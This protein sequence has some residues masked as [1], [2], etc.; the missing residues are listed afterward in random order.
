MT[1]E[2]LAYEMN[3]TMKNLKEAYV[4][5]HPESP[6]LLTYIQY[7]RGDEMVAVMAHGAD[8]ETMMEMGEKGRFCFSADRVVM[9]YE[10]YVTLKGINPY[11]GDPW[12]PGDIQHAAENEGGLDRG[13]T[14][15]TVM[16]IGFEEGH[17]VSILSPYRIEGE[18]VIW[19][20]KLPEEIVSVAMV[21][22]AI[23]EFFS[24]VMKDI[25][26]ADVAMRGKRDP[27]VNAEDADELEAA[28]KILREGMTEEEQYYHVDMVGLKYLMNLPDRPPM[29]MFGLA[30][31]RDTKRQQMI[32]ERVNTDDFFK[33]QGIEV[34]YSE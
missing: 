14:V 20:D 8:R 30:A 11:T 16:C 28:F 21:G 5:E 26:L 33:Q 34:K 9:V 31:G 17:D 13:V 6:D 18:E 22:G 24:E 25:T 4:K 10:G 19:I 7:Y 15:E 12:E 27:S 1:L 29:M 23:Q 3:E 32:D 2:D